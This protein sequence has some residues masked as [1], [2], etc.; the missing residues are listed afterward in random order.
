MIF[1]LIFGGYNFEE[2]LA[3]IVS[4]R[5]FFYLNGLKTFMIKVENFFLITI[6]GQKINSLYP[7]IRFIYIVAKQSASLKPK[8]VTK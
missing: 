4:V 7:F 8:Y 2:F 1:F 6:T 3:K 5:F